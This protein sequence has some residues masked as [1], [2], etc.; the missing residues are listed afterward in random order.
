MGWRL[1]RVV[2]VWTAAL[3]LLTAC[4]PSSSRTA[5]AVDT[6]P[7][8]YEVSCPSNDDCNAS[9]AL[10][11]GL[12]APGEPTRCTAALIGA[13]HRGHRWPLCD[14]RAHG[15]RGMWR[16][17]A[18]VCR[19]RGSSARVDRLR[20]NRVGID[21]G[22]YVAVTRLRDLGA[23]RGHRASSDSTRRRGGRIRGRRSNGFGYGRPLL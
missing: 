5:R 2:W 21:P 4:Q 15:Q 12:S 3:L 17:V 18:G 8:R 11:V 14:P 1:A 20:A 6:G 19:D 13:P 7:P 16:R 23:R 9:V 10:L 22:R